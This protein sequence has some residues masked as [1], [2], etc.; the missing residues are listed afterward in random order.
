MR[1]REKI[2]IITWIRQRKKS[3]REK[4]SVR[5]KTKKKSVTERMSN[6]KGKRNRGG[7]SVGR[8][9]DKVGRVWGRSC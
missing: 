1:G 5:K 9:E 3:F 6:W 4:V 2:F 8:Y 7:H